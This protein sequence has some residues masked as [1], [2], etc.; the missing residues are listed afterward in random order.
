MALSPINRATNGSAARKLPSW[1]D[2]FVEH[3][4]AIESPVLFRRWAAITTVGAML[5]QRV[6]VSTPDPLYPNMY[7]FLVGY[8]GV[9]KTR[10]IHAAAG[11]VREL[12]DHHLAPTSVTSASL[13]DY[14]ADKCHRIIPRMGQEAIEY[15]SMYFMVDELSDFMPKYSEELIGSLTNFYTTQPYSHYRRGKDIKIVMHSP[16]LSLLLGS[17][18]THLLRLL[19]DAAWDGGFASRAIIIFSNEQTQVDD[20][21]NTKSNARPKDMVHDLDCIATVH[22]QFDVDKEYQDAYNTFRKTK[23]PAGPSHPR[24]VHYNTRRRAHILKLSMISNVDRGDSLQLTKKDFNRAMG[25]L[26]EAEQFMGDIFRAGATGVDS[27]AM[28][29]IRH[30]IETMNGKSISEHKLVNFA[31]ERVPAHAVLRVIEIMERGGLI[32]VVSVDK[33]TGLRMYQAMPKED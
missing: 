27:A 32:K 11:F 5:E 12:T 10:T 22:G 17:T 19:P 28:D 18:P 13:V 3:T 4:A 2:A 1:I 7:T 21:F 24:M 16:Q 25:W 20:V 33:R 26:L 31:R 8:P 9:G 29:E 23:L 15:H 6:W 30:Y 14:M